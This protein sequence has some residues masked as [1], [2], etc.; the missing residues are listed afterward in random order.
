[1]LSTWLALA[2]PGAMIST[3]NSGTGTIFAVRYA[4]LP[5]VVY[6][7]THGCQGTLYTCSMSHTWFS[8]VISCLDQGFAP[9]AMPQDIRAALILQNVTIN[10][11]SAPIAA[12]DNVWLVQSRFA[13]DAAFNPAN[14]DD[15]TI[16]HDENLTGQA[17]KFACIHVR[18][19]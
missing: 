3:S 9:A 5:Q 8:Q 17:M 15:V 19:C 16:I 4:E 11:S 13:T 6:K 7:V 2:A 18:T 10:I 1:M 14:P 12:D